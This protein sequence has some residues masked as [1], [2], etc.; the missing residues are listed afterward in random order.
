M[1][2]PMFSKL[3]RGCLILAACTGSGCLAD[4]VISASTP[5]ETSISMLEL[6][7]ALF[8]LD[9]ADGYSIAQES[10]LW[11]SNANAAL[12]TNMMELITTLGGNSAMIAELFE[13]GAVF[14]GQTDPLA[15]T[16]S[17]TLVN[18]P[19][20]SSQLVSIQPSIPE[21]ATMGLLGE[22]LLF[23]C[24]CAFFRRGRM[25]AAACQSQTQPHGPIRPAD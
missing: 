14:A 19:G 4:S 21:P 17:P 13:P 1:R 10:Q 24:C 3:V 8:G 11:T 15:V 6:E 5:A 25:R 18:I 12:Y 23:L 16:S 9:P 7:E 20:V 22:A 2:F